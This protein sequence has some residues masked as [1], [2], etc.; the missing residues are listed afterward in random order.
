M[1]LTIAPVS[2]RLRRP[3]M[4]A[5]GT[6]DVRTGWRVALESDGVVGRGE[7][8][9][10]ES[11]GTESPEKSLAALEGFAIDALP[12]SVA[13]IRAAVV[14]LKATP[15]ARFAVEGAM[16]EHLARRQNVA[17][18]QLF[19]REVRAQVLVNAL[20]E[21]DDAAGLGAAAER[22]VSE[23][24][25]VVK[26]KVA[27]RSL[28][29]DAQR[30]LSVRRA[31]GPNVKLRIDANGGWTEATARSALRG[32]ET[33]D[34]EVCEQPVGSINIEGLRRLRRAVPCRIAADE[35][36]LQGDLF[37]RVLESD[38]SAAVDVLVLKPMALGGLI[39]SLELALKAMAL[40][41][42]SYATTLMDGPLGRAAAAHL[43]AILPGEHWAHGLSTVELLDGVPDDA[44]TPR[45]G[46]IT[47]PMTAGWGVS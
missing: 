25:E 36:M 39:P 43:A 34:L 17:V 10:M 37:E 45:K 12:N 13:D 2:Y 14:G 9:P 31:V 46:R 19:G 4:T 29:I 18:A 47:M 33:L 28:V 1:K 32:L 6:M 7:S 21:G 38:P 20:I 42:E 24:F 5:I 26:V 8:M 27:A 40:G 30:L 16:L 3:I 41:V 22:A 23:G 35:T 11:F 15:A 44:F